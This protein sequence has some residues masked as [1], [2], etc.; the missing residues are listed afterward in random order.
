MAPSTA[1]F[2]VARSTPSAAATG[3]YRSSSMRGCSKCPVA[4]HRGQHPWLDL[5]E[6]GTDEHVPGLG[7]DRRTHQRRHV[8]QAGRRGH[9][10]GGA[11]GRRPLAAQ[12][13][14]VSEVLVEPAVSE[15]GV[16]A[17]GL[18]PREQRLDHRVRV[19]QRLQPPCAG[20][21]HLDAHSPQQ[22]LHLSRTPQVVRTPDGAS[23]STCSS[24][25]ARA[26]PPLPR[27]AAAVRRVTR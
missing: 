2:A 27:C 5:A 25:S 20:V 21:G 17:L 16:D 12:S 22:R 26:R 19:A 3:A 10:A 9:P 23:C 15:R 6:V 11:V 7:H 4:R 18:S 8:V 24:R 1:T 14:V 13:A